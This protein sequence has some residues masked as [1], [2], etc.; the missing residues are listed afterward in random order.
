LEVSVTDSS[1]FGPAGSAL[2]RRV[3]GEFELSTAEQILLAEVC[4]TADELEILREA[5]ESADATVTGSTGQT[6]VNP[7]FRELREHRALYV[8]LIGE[9]ALPTEEEEKGRT[10]AQ[11]RAADAANARWRRERERWGRSGQA[12]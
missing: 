12:S 9:L 6:K 4:H 10:P 2:W 5:S 3:T 1:K 8:K 11:Q 7:L